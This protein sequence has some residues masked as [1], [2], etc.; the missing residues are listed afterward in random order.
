MGWDLN[1]LLSYFLTQ[2]PAEILSCPRNHIM[3]PIL[4]RSVSANAEKLKEFFVYYPD[5]PKKGIQFWD[6]FALYSNPEAVCL[7]NLVLAGYA[8]VMKGEIDVV[9]GIE[10]RGFLFG[11]TLANLLNCTFVPVR[12]KGKLPGKIRQKTYTLEYGSDTI[13]IQ[14]NSLKAGQR[15]LVVDDCIATGGTLN[16][17]CNL[18]EEIGAKVVDC[19][20]I[21]E[22]PEL[23]GSEKISYPITQLCS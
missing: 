9:V 23:K 8:E 5:F 1:L 12:K 20:V 17:S 22:I 14:E 4:P 6:I 16:A 3:P 10:A 11:P 2:F 13:E 15:V 19:L 18:V 21:Y 7:L